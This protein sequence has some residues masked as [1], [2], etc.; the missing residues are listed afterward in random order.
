MKLGYTIIYAPK[1]ESSLRFFEHAFGF[2]QRFL[3]NSADYGEL[4]TGETTLAFASHQ[5]GAMNSPDDHIRAHLLN[6]TCAIAYPQ[7]T[8]KPK[9]PFL[10]TLKIT[11][12]CVARYRLSFFR[13]PLASHQIV[14]VI[15]R[16]AQNPLVVRH[17]APR[18]RVWFH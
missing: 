12:Q 15:V 1:V 18:L 4:S 2:E 6:Q 10:S 14:A 17:R 13:H 11:T 16:C 9:E 5:L 8:E 7:P 3:H